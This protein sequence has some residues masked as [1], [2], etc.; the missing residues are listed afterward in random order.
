MIHKSVHTVA[1]F[2]QMPE[3]ERGNVKRKRGFAWT[4]SKRVQAVGGS[5]R[6]TQEASPVRPEMRRRHPAICLLIRCA[7]EHA[8][9][10]GV[11]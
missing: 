11:D 3:G 1:R 6:Q 4:I 8:I 2:F 10:I 9:Q 7:N 5:L